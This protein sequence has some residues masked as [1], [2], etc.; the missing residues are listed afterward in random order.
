MRLGW[1]RPAMAQIHWFGKNRF[2]PRTRLSALTALGMRLGFD[3]RF[4][5]LNLP[6]S[7]IAVVEVHRFRSD[8]ALESQFSRTRASVYFKFWISN[9]GSTF[10]LDV[11]GDV[12]CIANLDRAKV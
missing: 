3:H 4:S 8:L 6:S 11:L 12:D 9:A 5:S 1:Q 2:D 10:V 7:S